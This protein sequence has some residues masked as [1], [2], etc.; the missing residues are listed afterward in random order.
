MVRVPLPC[1]ESSPESVLSVREPES[2]VA[3][4]PSMVRV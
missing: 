1:F 3:L 2:V 4:L